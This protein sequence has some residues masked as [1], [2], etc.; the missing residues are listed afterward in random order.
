MGATGLT[1]ALYN[2]VLGGEQIWIVADKGREWP[3]Y[4]LIGHRGPEGAVGRRACASIAD[5][6]GKRIGVTQLGS[7]FHYHIGNIL[8]KNGLKL[9]DVKIVPLQAM[10]AT[11]EALKGKQVDAILRAPALPRRRGGAGLRQDPR[12]GGR[13]LPVADRGDL[14]LEGLRRRSRQAP[15]PS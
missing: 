2:I 14:L 9:A 10:P 3:G 11:V 1:A 6:K 7:T 13:P 8:E 15:S 12:V 4:P 5:L